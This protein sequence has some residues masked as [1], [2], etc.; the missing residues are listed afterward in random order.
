[1]CALFGATYPERTAALVIYGSYAKG[2]ATSDYPHGLAEQEAID[3]FVEALTELWDD[4]GG[5]L[6]IW[7]PVP[8]TIP[9]PKRPSDVTCAQ[10]RARAR[11]WRSPA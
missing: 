8:Q 9:S 6:N 1:M 10:A 5:L 2:T 4:A 3:E 11:S 7:A